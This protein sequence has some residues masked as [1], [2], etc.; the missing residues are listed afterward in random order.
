MYSL[1][2]IL[3]SLNIVLLVLVDVLPNIILVENSKHSKWYGGK[4]EK[5]EMGTYAREESLIEKG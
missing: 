1:F 5:N 2:L 3:I 4:N